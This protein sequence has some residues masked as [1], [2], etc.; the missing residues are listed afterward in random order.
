M[1][2]SPLRL[3]MSFI[4]VKSLKWDFN[5]YAGTKQKTKV[6]SNSYLPANLPFDPP[7]AVGEEGFKNSKIPN[8]QKEFR[9]E[10]PILF[11]L[12]PLPEAK[13]PVSLKM[14]LCKV[15]IFFLNY[16]ILKSNY[17]THSQ[18]EA[19]FK[20]FRAPCPLFLILILTV[21]LIVTVF[22]CSQKWNSRFLGLNWC[23]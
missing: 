23:I 16:W 11:T 14:F 19:L 8:E 7:A 5:I 13:I 22:L 6:P 4:I 20:H 18:I 10:D 12:P 2:F 15:L 3:K 17:I 9:F 21:A 1:Y